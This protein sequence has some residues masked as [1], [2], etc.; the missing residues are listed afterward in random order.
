M[1]YYVLIGILFLIAIL[2]LAHVIDLSRKSWLI[3]YLFLAPHLPL[4]LYAIVSDDAPLEGIPYICFL[5]FLIFTQLYTTIRLHIHKLRKNESGSVRIGILYGGRN[6]IHAGLSGLYLLPVWYFLCY[7]ILPQNPY[8]LLQYYHH[9]CAPWWQQ[10]TFI[11]MIE[12]IYAI[13]FVWLFL[14]NGC[15]RIF[16]TSRNLG[17]V[18]RIFILLFMWVPF[19][20]LYLAHML[21]RAAKDEYLVAVH[22]KNLDAFQ[23]DDTACATK[24]P[25]IMV[26]GIGF[27]DLRYFNYWGRIPMLLGKHGAKVYYGHQNAWGTIEEN[28]SIIAAT[29]DNALSE[30][31]CDKVNLIAH[32][33]GGLDCRYLICA[34]GYGD[35]V[36]SLTTINTPHYGSELITLLNKLPDS[37]YRLIASCLNHP[38]A[39]AGDDHPDCYASSKQLDPVFCAHFNASNPDNPNVYYQSYASVMKSCFSDSLLSIPYLLMRCCKAGANDGLVNVDSAKWGN[40]RGVLKNKYHRGISHGDMIDLKR[41]DIKGFDVLNVFYEIVVELKQNG[42]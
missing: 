10:Q 18:K 9:E 41:E 33:K 2:D 7:F 4:L 15:L 37:I 16:F 20:Q 11:L 24:Y 26:H 36:A 1:W 28:A 29:I 40:F 17:I 34:M 32:S 39:L 14:I 8:H 27:R 22:R 25:I 13:I 19:V 3:P 5:F 30:N 21:C 42:F 23:V 12:V 31:N 35:K 6:L 38:F